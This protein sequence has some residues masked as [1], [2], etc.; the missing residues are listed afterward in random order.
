VPT[1]IMRADTDQGRATDATS[2]C[3]PVD[4]TA[5]SATRMGERA[6][7]VGDRVINLQVPGLFTVVD[8]QGALLVLEIPGGVRMTVHESQARRLDD[9]APPQIPNDG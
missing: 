8:R 2:P 1:P 9:V 4:R 6:I 3:N 5:I 7:Q